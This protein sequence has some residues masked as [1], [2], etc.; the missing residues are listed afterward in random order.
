MDSPS[1]SNE[2][3][4]KL[5]APPPSLAFEDVI[6]IKGGVLI[7]QGQS[8]KSWKKRLFLLTEKYL[9]YYVSTQDKTPRGVIS[10]VGCAIDQDTALSK[11]KGTY[12]FSLRAERSWNFKL[13]K[14]F[15]DRTYYFCTS[16]LSEINDWI[17]LIRAL[18][19]S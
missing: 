2:F 8:H 5:I 19:K 15:Q 14:S 16:E 11:E 12:C 9:Y 10:L 18:S 4:A 1:K 3:E 7:K 13:S 6:P 17:A